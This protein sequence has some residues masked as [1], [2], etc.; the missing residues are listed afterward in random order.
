MR[1]S[2]LFTERR[3]KLRLV[4]PN[5]TLSIQAH[6]EHQR[7]EGK[8]AMRG[9]NLPP[10]LSRRKGEA[11]VS[12]MPSRLALALVAALTTSVTAQAT[13]VTIGDVSIHLPTPVGFCE[14]SAR[15][16]YDNRMLTAIGTIVSKGGNELLSY[17]ADCK[18]LVDWRA[19]ERNFLDDFVQ[20]QTPANKMDQLVASPEASIKNTCV[21]LRTKGDEINSSS[22]PEVKAH[23]EETLKRATLNESKWLGVLDEDQTACYAAMLQKML[24]EAG[25]EKTQISLIA[26]TVIKK[27]WIF[28]YRYTVYKGPDTAINLLSEFKKTISALYAVN[29]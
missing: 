24:T 5:A 28:L 9:W 6:M 23:I 19:G 11:L 17:S 29:K 13:E 1:K 2:P 21:G 25:T 22:T 8:N 7:D 27:K 26:W 16:K 20:Y 3:E 12:L 10:R 15:N 18:Q 14:L 4:A